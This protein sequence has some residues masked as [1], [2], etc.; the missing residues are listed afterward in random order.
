M[1]QTRNLAESHNG[2]GPPR[3]RLARIRCLLECVKCFHE[4]KSMP[5][6][7]CYVASE[8]EYRSQCKTTIK[9][10]PEPRK[11]K[12]LTGFQPRE[13][14]LSPESRLVA[15][16]EE[17]CDNQGKWLKLRKVWL[18]PC[19]FEA[20]HLC[21]TSKGASSYQ[22][23]FA[24]IIVVLYILSSL[25]GGGAPVLYICVLICRRIIDIIAKWCIM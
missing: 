11:T 25:L 8:V 23:C 1:S 20:N 13:L 19:L 21:S 10:Y 12:K 5:E 4:K 16:G 22:M 3:R 17:F 6:S 18:K 14:Q 24:I 9:L 7:F 15:T 2:L